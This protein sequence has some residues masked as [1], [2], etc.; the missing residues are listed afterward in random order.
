MLG[1]KK[2][3]LSLDFLKS[4]HLDNESSFNSNK[5]TYFEYERGLPL[6]KIEK[7]W[8]YDIKGIANKTVLFSNGMSAIDS[9]LRTL[10]NTKKKEKV[11]IVCFCAY[12]ETISLLK[13]YDHAHLE[14][15]F[16]ETEN[17]LIKFLNNDEVDI[18]FVEPT[19]YNWSLDKI[20][21]PNLLRI[22]KKY[23]R[24]K[25]VYIVT[26]TTLHGENSIIE[27]CVRSSLVDNR[28][29]LFLDIKSG[30]KLNQLGLEL[31]NLGIVNI[32]SNSAR[33]NMLLNLADS[34]KS[35]RVITGANL[36]FYELCLLDSKFLG[37]SQDIKNY[38]EKI[39][40]NNSFFDNNLKQGGC[41]KK[42]VFPRGS[43]NKLPTPFLFIHLYNN[44]D[45]EK[46]MD[47][48]KDSFEKKNIEPPVGNSFG[49]RETRLELIKTKDEVPTKVIKIACGTYKGAS[50]LLL[51]NLFNQLSLTASKTFDL[52]IEQGDF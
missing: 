30:L 12:F 47:Y 37:N 50:F 34:L 42:I 11:R 25:M 31:S 6:D 49:F 19:K 26:D 46:V 15:I 32:Y 41:I 13:L 17:T 33:Y 23:K 22:L 21:M 10:I 27:E 7:N 14:I 20:N 1:R 18:L 24:N 29:L 44:D 16:A 38:Q 5:N 2:S 35:V 36:S 45:Y 52:N 3:N 4:P 39:F 9:V 48:I 28:N 40:D 8:Q 43:N 51:L